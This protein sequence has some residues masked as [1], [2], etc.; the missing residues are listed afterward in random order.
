MNELIHEPNVVRI[1]NGSLIDV[2]KIV[3]ISRPSLYRAYNGA[4]ADVH[5]SV[6]VYADS[7]ILIKEYPS[8]YIS[9]YRYY[10][11]LG[12]SSHAHWKT[13][14]GEWKSNP[15]DD[16]IEFYTEFKRKVDILVA[17]WTKNKEIVDLFPKND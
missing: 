6:V 3:S 14:T 5:V 4:M 17:F 1:W 11:E 7:D 9:V 8:P 15:T 10:D 16:E 2:N 12:N 13:I